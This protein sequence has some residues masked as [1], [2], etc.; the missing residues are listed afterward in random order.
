MPVWDPDV[1]L[2]FAVHRAR[3][4]HDL[5]A[6]IGPWLDRD[7]RS[8]VDLGCGP[9]QLSAVLR[10]RWPL[11]PVI[12]IDSSPEM[13]SR[14]NADN[15]DPLTTYVLGDVADWQPSESVDLVISNATF[16]WVPDQLALIPR[17]R[18]HLAPG[19]VL[20]LSVPHN[21][22]AP[23]HAELHRLADEPPYAEH[24]VDLPRDRGV[25]AA[26]YLDLLA[27]PGWRVDAWTT[28]YEHVLRGDDAVFRWVGGTGARPFL[29]A[30]PE[31]LRSRFSTTY[32]ERLRAAYPRRSF[33]TVLAFERVFVVTQA[34]LRS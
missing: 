8:I 33:G 31:Q 9:G 5:V 14:A 22:T 2:S 4:F 26:A 10:D 3:P 11:T 28:T 34:D 13:I 12:G 25:S 29:Q 24:L 30:L 32:A 21:Y 1:Y 16:Q 15:T 6:R 18:E 27:T 19:G 23:S 7:P 20:A 17:L